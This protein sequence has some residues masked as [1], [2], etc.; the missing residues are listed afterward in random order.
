[1]TSVGIAQRWLS[2]GIRSVEVLTE[3]I[4]LMRGMGDRGRDHERVL[5]G[6]STETMALIEV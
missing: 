5:T 4:R 3:N 1:M 2:G 6:P